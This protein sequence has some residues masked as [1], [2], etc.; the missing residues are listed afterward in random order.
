M[1]HTTDTLV[2][3]VNEVKPLECKVTGIQLVP[4]GLA[5]YLDTSSLL[6]LAVQKHKLS[7]DE[8][9]DEDEDF[10]WSEFLAD[11]ISTPLEKAIIAMDSSLA[12]RVTA[13]PKNFIANR[14]TS[15][16]SLLSITFNR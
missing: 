1:L 6:R 3:I 15:G 2:K 5:V 4:Q 10:K 12:G 13:W 8:N 11:E 9:E 7:Q 16:W 14:T